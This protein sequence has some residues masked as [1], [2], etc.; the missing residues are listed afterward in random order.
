MSQGRKLHFLVDSGADISLV[1]SYKFLRAAE[2]QPKDSVSVKCVEGS[3]IET[4]GSVDKDT[5]RTD[6]YSLSFPASKQASESK[7]TCDP[8]A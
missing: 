2:F 6:R 1:K 8:R 5:G 7:R 4:H 3:V